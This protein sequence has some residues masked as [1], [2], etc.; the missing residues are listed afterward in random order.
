MATPEYK[1]GY[2]EKIVD[3]STLFYKSFDTQDS[4]GSVFVWKSKF[5]IGFGNVGNI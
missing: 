5:T 4:P 2:F 3:N 1:N